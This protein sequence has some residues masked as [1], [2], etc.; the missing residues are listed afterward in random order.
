MIDHRALF[1]V[2]GDLCGSMIERMG[3]LLAGLL[4]IVLVGLGGLYVAAGR[5]APPTLT[6]DKP[7]RVVGQ[8]GTLEVTAGAPRDRL[9]ASRHA[10]TER[11]HDTLVHSR[12]RRIAASPRSTRT[13]CA[14]RGRS[15]SRASRSC[16]PAARASSSPRRASRSW[17]CERSRARSARTSRSGSSRRASPWCRRTTTSTTAARRWSSTAPRPPTCSRASGSATSSTPA[18]RRPVAGFRRRPA[19]PGL[20]VAFFALL[21]DQD[22]KT[23]IAVFARDEA[24]N[25]ARTTVRRQG[26]RETV[27]AEPHR[28]RRRVHRAGR[29]GDP[30][31]L[32]GAED[33]GPA[34]AAT[35]CRHSSRSTATCA[36]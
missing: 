12:R 3:R 36:S 11:P 9:T 24:G 27:Q 25:E 19:D 15:A 21:H 16:S 30:G 8:T 29:A 13:T 20:N 28:A 14:S 10:R 32:A 5:T 2:R 7:E 1:S 31:A 23:P 4:L 18:F 33:G 26:L 17:D 22:L 34:P 35:C 6:I